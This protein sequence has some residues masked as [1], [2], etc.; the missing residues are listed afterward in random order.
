MDDPKILEAMN[1]YYRYKSRYEEALQAKKRVIIKNTELSIK[2]KRQRFQLLKIPCVHCK[3]LVGTTFIESK[4]KLIAKCGAS[5]RGSEKP[6]NF[7][8]EIQKGNFETIP[9]AIKLFEE[10]KEPDKD[11]IIKTKLNLFFQFTNEANTMEVFSK[12]KKDFIE[13][14]KEY[15]A[16]LN[17]LIQATPYLKNKASIHEHNIKMMEKKIEIRELIQKSTSEKNQQYIKDAVELYTKD[18]MPMI[19]KHRALN[20]SY[21][22]LEDDLYNDQ[23]KRLVQSEISI[24]NTEFVL[25]TDPQIIN[26]YK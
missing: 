23:I 2:E 8:I 6:C 19:E 24:K 18:L 11:D 1:T 10:G 15:E 12:I 17:E 26:Y 7:K 9:W 13:H 20:Y 25:D 14:N 4:R 21:Y 5:G 16:Y 3:N 22:N